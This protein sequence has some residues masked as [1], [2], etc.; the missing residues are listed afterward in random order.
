MDNQFFYDKIILK[1]KNGEQLIQLSENLMIN[2]T[3]KKY[4][5]EPISTLDIISNDIMFIKA[6]RY[7]KRISIGMEHSIDF[8]RITF[9]KIFLE[10][11]DWWERLI[12]A[13]KE[14]DIKCTK[15]MDEFTD[16]D[17]EYINC[18]VK[19]YSNKISQNYKSD[20]WMMWWEDKVYP[21]YI[22]DRVDGNK[23]GYNLLASNNFWMSIE[24]EGQHQIIP[25]FF[26][27]K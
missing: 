10:R 16:T 26:M 24:K 9:P 27:Y 5:F 15:R 4:H 22:A 3:K 18:L 13:F 20:W 19:I 17:W 6:L 12:A 23:K 1:D 2:D 7:G 11:L 8:G 25:N 14:Y 21:I